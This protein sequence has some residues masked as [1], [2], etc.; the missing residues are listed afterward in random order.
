[1]PPSLIDNEAYFKQ[2]LMLRRQEGTTILSTLFVDQ[3]LV[4]GGSTGHVYLFDLSIEM[5]ESVW[6]TCSTAGEYIPKAKASYLVHDGPVSSLV[7]HNDMLY[8]ASYGEM[9]G[10]AWADI[11]DGCG[12]R[13]IIHRVELRNPPR[14]GT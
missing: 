11:V 14:E 12:S 1:M 5:A 7:Y 13:S 4:A 10:W 2:Q 6:D 9:R 3:Y 8:T